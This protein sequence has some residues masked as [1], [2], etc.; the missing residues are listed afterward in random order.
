MILEKALTL[1]LAQFE[2]A[3]FYDK[4]TRARREASTRPL[5]LVMRTF[6]LAQ[7]AVSLASYGV[8]LVQ[9]S[10]W[11]SRCCARRPA[12]LRRRGEVLRRRLPPVPLALARDAHA[13]VPRDR[14]RA[15][16]PR[17]GG[18]AVRPRAARLLAATAPS[19]R[20]STARTAR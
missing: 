13:D 16:G 12:G 18:Q 1:E 14:A 3:E 15:R 11:A 20:S 4:L 19:S 7:N 6:G 5:S 17:Q 10:P 8:L 9:F 2:D